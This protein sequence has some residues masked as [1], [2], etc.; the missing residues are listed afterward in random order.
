[1]RHRYGFGLIFLKYSFLGVNFLF[2]KLTQHQ[3]RNK[4][5]KLEIVGNC[6]NSKMF[7]YM[8]KF[9]NSVNSIVNMEINILN[10][11]I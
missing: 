7:K 3:N 5:V 11:K 9:V 8:T 10:K 4:E 6:I 1:M 2:L